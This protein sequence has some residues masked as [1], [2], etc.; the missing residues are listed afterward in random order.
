ML[1]KVC[2]VKNY[3]YVKQ[4]ID[5]LLNDAI[6]FISVDSRFPPPPLF[7]PPPP[8]VGDD[9]DY[10]L[11]QMVFNLDKEKVSMMYRTESH[12]NINKLNKV[13]FL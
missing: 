9:M 10:L 7:P 4:N 6:T 2:N 5:I 1:V 13:N 11:R 8:S 3:K 12:I